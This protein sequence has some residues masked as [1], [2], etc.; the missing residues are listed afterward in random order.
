MLNKVIL[1]GR[2]T[3]EPEL[4]ASPSGI[5]V[6]TFSLAVERNYAR[7]GPAEDPAD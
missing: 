7:Q 1:M 3:H 2:I 6:L 4:K 5:S